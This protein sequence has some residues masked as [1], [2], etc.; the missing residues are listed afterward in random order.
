[1][2]VTVIHGNTA[3]KPKETSEIVLG[4]GAHVVVCLEEVPSKGRA[5]I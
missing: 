3:K 1:M 2:G 4:L 5:S